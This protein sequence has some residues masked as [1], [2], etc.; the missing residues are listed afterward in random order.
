VAPK[1]DRIPLFDPRSRNYPVRALLPRTVERRQRIWA[2]P[3][4]FPLDQGEEGACVGHGFAAELAADPIV[5]P[6]DQAFAFELYEQARAQDRAMGFNFPAGATMLGGAKAAHAGGHIS[7]YRWAFGPDDVID[8]IVE[9]S[10]VVLG[11]WWYDSM[12]QT[13]SRGLVDISGPRVGGHCIL[14]NGY[15]PNHP[16]FGEC[17]T[18]V[19]SWG[20]GYGINGLGYV[21]LPDLARLLA[22]QGEA[23]IVVD[24]AP[25]PVAPAAERVC[26]SRFGYAF[27]RPG[28]HWWVPCPRMFPNREAATAEGL[29]ACR[30]CKP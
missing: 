12:Y 7:S 11:I 13:D 8:T 21:R 22:D 2:L 20:P 1:L 28:S 3:D 26:A 18:W 23:C 6:T 15:L 14:A 9:L 4:H 5:V 25:K 30:L 24:V 10:P 16:Q 17:I 19:N 29:R 27:H